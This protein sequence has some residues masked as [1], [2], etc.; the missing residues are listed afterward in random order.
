[1]ITER[2][3]YW[4]KQTP[5]NTAVIQNGAH[6]SYRSFARSIAK[7]RGYFIRQGFAGPGHA[8]LA[9]HSMKDFW[10]L[11]LALRSLGLTTLAARS[12]AALNQFDLPDLRLVVTLRAEAWPELEGVCAARGLPLLS[13]SLEGEAGIPLDAAGEHHP[14]GGHTV[15]T[16]GTTG[17]DKMLLLRAE[18]DSIYLPIMVKATGID[19]KT[20]LCMFGISGWTTV[21]YRWAAAPWTV[22]GATFF[23]PGSERYLALQHPGLTHAFMNPA[24]LAGVLAA[25]EDGFPRNDVL[26]LFVGGGTITRAQVDQAKARIT[27]HIFNFLAATEVGVIAVTP[28]DTPEDHRWHRPVPSRLVEVV[29]DS[30]R[31]APAGENGLLRVGTTGGPESYIDDEAA[32]RTFFKDGFFYPGDLAVMRPDGRI[33]LQ[34]RVTEVINVRGKKISPA[35]IEDRLAEMFQVNAVCLFSEQNDDGEEELHVVLEAPA[36]FEPGRVA[37]A[38]KELRGFNK[39]I[40]HFVAEMPRNPMGKVLR[41]EAQSLARS[42]PGHT[43]QW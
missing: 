2:I 38:L 12:V 7:A 3:F 6:L 10:I 11:G 16:S 18:Y 8:V 42:N 28:L 35:P 29:D 23:Q 21:G 26:Q 31:P 14:A 19:Q 41:R 37:D 34:G 25:P 33:A 1:M 27:P 9:I 17:A 32:T 15:W 13:A 5:Y 24:M 40:V 39:A 43:I 36:R 20:V 4:A 30:G 22:G